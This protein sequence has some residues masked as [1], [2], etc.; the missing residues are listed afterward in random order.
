MLPYI[1]FWMSPIFNAVRMLYI[2]PISWKSTLMADVNL[3]TETVTLISGTSANKHQIAKFCL[4]V[5]VGSNGYRKLSFTG[6][7][8]FLIQETKSVIDKCDNRYRVL[9]V[10]MDAAFKDYSYT[11]ASYLTIS[12]IRKQMLDV[13]AGAGEKSEFYCNTTD[14][15]E[16]KA[17][18]HR[19]HDF[20]IANDKIYAWK[21]ANVRIAASLRQWAEEAGFDTCVYSTSPFENEKDASILY[22]LKKTL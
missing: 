18:W 17:E 4:E 9:K 15:L 19:V 11:D 13:T 10:Y 22:L 16:M 21:C 1:T 2:S 7:D 3:N 8:L 20:A 14:N 6:N 12:D 5:E